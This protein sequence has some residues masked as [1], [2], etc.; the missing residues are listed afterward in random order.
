[1]DQLKVCCPIPSRIL[2][3]NHQ[4]LIW[5]ARHG[6]EDEN[7]ETRTA[8]SLGLHSISLIS[9]L[10][11]RAWPQF[12]GIF[13]RREVRKHIQRFLWRRHS[14]ACIFIWMRQAPARLNIVMSIDQKRRQA[15]MCS[16]AVEKIRRGELSYWY[17]RR[18]RSHYPDVWNI[19]FRTRLPLHDET[20]TNL[21]KFNV[22]F[23]AV[24]YTINIIR[25]HGM[26]DPAVVRPFSFSLSL[27]AIRTRFIPHHRVTICSP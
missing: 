1:M 19:V 27:S 20:L 26:V 8:Y 2:Q 17:V 18:H 23:S 12:E 5:W 22:R 16:T 6:I 14:I 10:V 4:F 3:T 25:V 11:R 7:G 13:S 24:H 15:Q 9:A 21:C